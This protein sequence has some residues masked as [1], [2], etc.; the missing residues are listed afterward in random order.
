MFARIFCRRE[1]GEREADT[2]GRVFWIKVDGR[3]GFYETFPV[4]VF[5]REERQTRAEKPA[6]WPRG[7]P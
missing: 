1:N 4:F 7:Y 3:E 5:T 6:D 2:E